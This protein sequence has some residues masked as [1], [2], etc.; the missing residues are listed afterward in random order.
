[1]YIFQVITVFKMV[2]KLSLILLTLGYIIRFDN[3]LMIV[4][5]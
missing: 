2:T 4:I 1:M 3:L 5:N